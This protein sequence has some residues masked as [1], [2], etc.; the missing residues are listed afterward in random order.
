MAKRRRGNQEN[1]KELES[2]SDFWYFHQPV[3][4]A[5]EMGTSYRFVTY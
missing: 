1:H 2:V 4:T 5:R 3:E